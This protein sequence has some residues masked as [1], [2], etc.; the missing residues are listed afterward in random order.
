MA[1]GT[2]AAIG[3]GLGAVGS[4]VSSSSANKAAGKAADTSL[5]VAEKNNAL[6]REIYGKNEA[7]LSPFMNT[8]NQ[9][10]GQINALLGLG[11]TGPTPG[12]PGSPDFAAYVQ[13]NPDLV[14]DF[15][16]SGGQYGNDINAYG[17]AHWGKF[18][19]MEGRNL[20]TSG[21]T[22]GSPA[23]SAEEAQRAAESAFNNYR[24]STGY[25]FRLGEGMNALNSGYAGRGVIQSGA[26]MKGAVEYGQNFG[27]NEFGNYLGALSNQ[28]GLGLQGASALAGVGQNYVN[29]ISANN[30]SA[31]SAA[32]NA[33]LAKG[34]NNPFG[35]ALGMLGG[36]L[37]GYGR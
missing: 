32:A 7:N 27:S 28:Q 6:S 19:Q 29:S 8:G 33:I 22:P 26:A 1:I 9:A 36:G 34:A 17:Q 12:T 18:G 21:G 2:I 37:Y 13:A 11:G 30:N 4:V 3:L 35:N 20:P 10:M 14:A 23:I 15:Q 31:G 5:A 16:R 25:Q 24:N